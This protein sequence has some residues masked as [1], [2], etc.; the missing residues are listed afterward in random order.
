MSLLYGIYAFLTFLFSSILFSGIFSREIE[1]QSIRFITPYLS[2]KK[3]YAAKLL[4][5]LTIF[6]IILT[7]S[8]AITFIVR[9]VGSFP[10]IDTLMFT[11]FLI[12]IQA[13][14]III[15]LLSPNDRLASIV[16]L[17]FSLLMPILFIVSNFV[18]N[19][20]VAAINWVLPYRYISME[21]SWEGLILVVLTILLIF[22]GLV[23]FERKEI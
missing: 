15:S 16:G 8:I 10:L 17:L 14:V 7:I 5:M 21:N 3:I 22:L 20:F 18:D 12:Y 13:I 1:N 2:K 11:M 4:T 19:K 23:I 6:A 9:S